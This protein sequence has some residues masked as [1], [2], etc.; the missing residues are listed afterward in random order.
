MP[1]TAG[2]KRNDHI[3]AGTLVAA[4]AFAVCAAGWWARNRQRRPYGPRWLVEILPRPALSRPRLLALL[5][6]TPGESILEIGPGYGYYSLAI[7]RR[8]AEAGELL[9]VDVSE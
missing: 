6:P 8:L 5:E 4:G 9:M 2:R 7:A 1:M 3:W